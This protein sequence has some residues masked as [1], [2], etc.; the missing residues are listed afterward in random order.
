M[1]TIGVSLPWD[2]LTG[3]SVTK[4][5][6]VVKTVLGRPEEG[7]KFLN[8][9]GVSSIELRHLHKS[10]SETD[11]SRAF[12][13]LGEAGVA[14]TIHSEDPPDSDNW[15]IS[16]LFPWFKILENGHSIDQKRIVIAL[17]PLTKKGSGSVE[18]MREGTI[19]MILKLMKKEVGWNHDYHF[20][21]ENQRVKGLI[22]PC[23]S[24]DTVLDV[25][26]AVNNNDLGICW[27]MGH[28]YANYLKNDHS[29]IPSEE[30][31]NL[32]TH[33]HIHDLGPG[34]ATHWPFLTE[35]VP[36]DRFIGLLRDKNYK[37]TFNLELSFDR[38]IDVENKKGLLEQSVSRISNIFG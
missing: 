35:T 1:N 28:G 10:L 3:N 27:D 20:S 4:E 17:H 22:D 32:T 13:L 30:F 26:Q 33:T 21:L 19:K 31:L 6:A 16:N 24:F 14:I 25:W 5:A 7:L 12:S 15:S 38:F 2:Y 23:T 18:E 34:G 11:M 37:G 36:L 9:I 8:E 29:L